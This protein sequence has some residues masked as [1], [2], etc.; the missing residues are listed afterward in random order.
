M[1]DPRHNESHLPGSRS[2]R[3]IR[4]GI[5]LGLGV[6]LAL[7]LGLAWFLSRERVTLP[8]IDTSNAHAELVKVVKEATEAVQE[9]PR[10]ADAWGQLGMVLLAHEYY[11]QASEC[12][13]QAA[14]RDPKNMLWLYYDALTCFRVYPNRAIGLLEK[15]VAINELDTAIRL[16]LGDLLLEEGRLDEAERHLTQALTKEEHQPWAHLRLAQLALRRE[17]LPQALEHAQRAEQGFRASSDFKGLHVLLAEIHFRM[18]EEKA[19]EQEHQKALNLPALKWPDPHM[20]KVDRLKVDVLGHLAQAKTLSPQEEIA[21]LEALV[22]THPQSVP[23]YVTLAQ[24]FEKRQMWDSVAAAS[25]Q[26]LKLNP[27]DAVALNLL[28]MAL[29][30]QGRLADAVDIYKR[31]VQ[32]N[33]QNADTYVQLGFCHYQLKDKEAAKD[34]LRHA[35]RLRANFAKAWLVL[36]QLYAEENNPDALVYLR[37]A[38]E[39]SPDDATVRKSLDDAQKRFGK[40]EPPK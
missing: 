16:L 38:L 36:G 22:R 12:F 23:A 4:W 34:A 27:D 20:E 13:I 9:N 19:A 25:S 5:A 24:A 2:R 26:A 28:G 7:V 15:A 40:S 21:G 8:I 35:V 6:V 32:R 39:L 14:K 3:S 29:S 33:P 1:S 17:K 10:S 30:Q 37:R 31:S 11:Q 18:G